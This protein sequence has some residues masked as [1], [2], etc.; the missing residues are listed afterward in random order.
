MF[1]ELLGSAILHYKKNFGVEED[2]ECMVLK[3]E[4]IGKLLC[5]AGF[6]GG[7][8]LRTKNGAFPLGQGAL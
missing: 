3:D 6:G 5:V 4:N 2:R 1:D 8:F 7:A